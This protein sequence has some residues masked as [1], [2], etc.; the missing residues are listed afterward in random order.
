MKKLL[1]FLFLF[2]NVYA[3]AQEGAKARRIFPGEGAPV[4]GRKPTGGQF[5]PGSL[6]DEYLDVNSLLLYYANSSFTWTQ[7]G[8]LQGG[9]GG[10][11][12]IV[13]TVTTTLP[14]GSSATFTISGDTA[15]VGIPQGQTGAT[16]TSG[17]GSSW[18]DNVF[19]GPDKYYAT[20]D[21]LTI[22]EHGYNQAAIDTMWP[23]IGATT[24]WTVDRAAWQ[25]AVNEATDALKKII[26]YGHYWTNNTIWAEKYYD[27]LVIDGPG[28]LHG[29][30]TVD[31]PLIATQA[32]TDNTDA[33]LMVS[34]QVIIRDMTF[35][36]NRKVNTLTGLNLGPSYMSRYDNLKFYDCDTAIMQRFQLGTLMT[37]IEVN[38]ANVTTTG[39]LGIWTGFGNWSGASNSN[40]QSNSTMIFGSR[41]Y[42]TNSTTTA[43]KIHACSGV[44]D[45]GQIIEGGAVGIGN[46][47]DG[48]SSTVVKDYS[49]YHQHFEVAGGA[50]TAANKVRL[51]GGIV[52]MDGVFGQYPSILM[53]A[54]GSP[55]AVSL[56]I[57]NVPYWVAKAG[58]V[59]NNAGA[60][61]W[62]PDWLDGAAW[63][64]GFTTVPEFASKFTGTPVTAVGVGTTGNFNNKFI[65]P[66]FNPK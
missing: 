62:Y 41:Y 12:T 31:F 2:I 44:V 24:S 9:G 3:I 61:L 42:M 39:R 40:S 58:K 64:G 47:V 53:D 32:P 21:S 15:Y 54:G 60:T 48:N 36:G 49:N 26:T 17:A 46:D 7:R 38:N 65:I 29:C 30:G 1:I 5:A 56:R 18:L 34:K 43:H 22:A 25:M 59:F 11:T 23:G 14:P 8:S 28:H 51:A 52:T 33:N 57:S 20:H 4:N 66:S 10:G 19:T 16:G 37:N 45:Y 13:A 35:G 63:N 6:G 50:T 27:K 55:G